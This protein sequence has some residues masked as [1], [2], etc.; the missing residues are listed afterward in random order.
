[1]EK[2]DYDVMDY[3]KKRHILYEMQI[4]LNTSCNLSCVHCYIPNHNNG[5]L[6]FET[7]KKI[8]TQA[9]ELKVFSIC[10]TGGEILLR[11]DI[12]D[13][14]KLIRENYMNVSLMSNAVLLNE[15]IISNLSDLNVSDYAISIY[16]LD[17]K[18]H[19][20]ITNQKGSLLKTLKNIEIL[21]KYNIPVT[22][23]CPVMSINFHSI[24]AIE[25]YCKDNDFKC[26]FTS[27]ITKK[28]N[29]DTM[30][31][32]LE[33][34][35]DQYRIYATKIS[36]E[37]EFNNMDK[38]LDIDEI[39]CGNNNCCLFINS[40]GDAYPCI[41]LPFKIGNIY[42]NNLYDIWNNSDQF[43]KLIS[44]KNSDLKEC[45]R[46]DVKQF[47]HRCPGLALSEQNDLYGCSLL[48]K[49]LAVAKKFVCEKY[50]T[51]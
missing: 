39:P 41:S 42:K 7:A 1:M 38:L 15:A 40:Y 10:L 35:E 23:N 25:K 19:D 14:I 31:C 4:E 8:I 21:K 51:T 3:C 26:Q 12:L 13:I 6:S 30:P 44:I 28:L 37:Q 34:S 32:N 22:I 17:E 33:M 11:K 27:A 16:S 18:V 45:L 24:D 36:T 49:K 46:C 47:C 50:Y 29:G 5:G 20:Y 9:R 2:I 48:D 43:K